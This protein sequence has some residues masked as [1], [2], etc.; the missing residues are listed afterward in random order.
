MDS[1]TLGSNSPVVSRVG[2]GCMG[3]SDF[4]GP[5]NDSESVATIHTALETGI[6]LPDTSDFYG[7]GRNELLAGQALQDRRREEIAQ[8]K[9]M[10]TARLAIAWGLS[11]GTDLVPLIGARTREWLEEALATLDAGLTEDD[12]ARMEQAVPPE[13]VAGARYHEAQSATLDSERGP[14]R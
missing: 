6:T 7:M 3:M 10:T 5:A 4:Y 14:R 1:C 2:L 11:R 9:G 13:Q 8:E 12:L